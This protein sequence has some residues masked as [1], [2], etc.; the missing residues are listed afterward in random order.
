MTASSKLA[1]AE[2]V[3]IIYD[4]LRLGQSASLTHILT[5][6]DIALFAAMSGDVNPAHLD[7]DYAALDRFHGI[8]GHGL[9]TGALFSTLLGTQLPGAGTIYLAQ[10]LSFLRP[11]RLGDTVTAT[12]T[13]R[14]KPADQKPRVTFSCIAVNQCQETVLEGTAIVL[15]P[16]ETI[17]RPRPDLPEFELRQ[18]ERMRAL[19]S[20]CDAL[21]PLPTA[22]VHPV[23]AEI[24]QAVQDAVQHRLIKPILIGPLPRIHAAAEAA[25]IDLS[26]WEIIAADHSHAAASEAVKRAAAGQ[27]SAIMK[28]TLHTDELLAP[29]VARDSGLRTERRMSHVYVMDQPH[30]HKLLLVTDAAINIAPD[31]LTKADILRN[32]ADLWR[33]LTG[34]QTPKI[35]LLAAVETVNPAMP[36]TLD[37]AALCKMAERGQITDILADGPLAF[38]NAISLQ[39]AKTKGLVSA[40]AGDADIVLAP[41]IEAGNVLAK[42]MSFLGGVEA[43]GI[44]LGARV[45]IILP[46]RADSLRAR[47]LS[48]ALAVLT[49]A[50]R[51][52]GRIK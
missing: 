37:A 11:V 2:L 34:Q 25:R 36:A 21:P 13:L 41:D 14:E 48:C 5:E 51:R 6:K 45:P 9:W 38:D 8:I 52:E 19:I 1:S 3:N 44:V 32:A 39:A 12:I 46:S 29:V 26:D 22:I 10:D 43:A 15:A 42:Q 33:V 30:Y 23:Q 49:A 18:H 17:R 7:R 35:A 28:G 40:V 50:A 24:L 20:A 16:T 4:D 47:L 27:V 31:L